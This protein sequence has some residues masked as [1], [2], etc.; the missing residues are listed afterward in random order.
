MKYGICSLASVPGRK[1]PSDPS[2]MVT[3]LL[4]GEQF[5]VLD[6]QQKWSQVRCLHDD[7]VCWID[8]KQFL[9]IE[10]PIVGI[11]SAEM[12]FG[13]G[14]LRIP[15]GSVLPDYQDGLFTWN[16]ERVPFPGEVGPMSIDDLFKDQDKW[17]NTP[18]L[19]GGRSPFGV[20]CSGL[21]QVMFAMVGISLPRDASQQI[22][23]GEPVQLIGLI[24]HGD[25]AFFDNDEG[26][27]THVGIVMD[28]S[29]ILHASGKVRVD[30]IDHQGIFNEET[31]LYTHKLRLVKRVI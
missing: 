6:H 21:T 13:A 14:E 26:R 10:S 25:L 24:E 1:E 20:D 30:R 16:N 28:G 8:N 27:I 18:Y 15:Y 3:Q 23:L 19:W 9:P 7:Y 11:R 22:E 31:K 4:F 29:R 5:E 17:L 12:L 2:E